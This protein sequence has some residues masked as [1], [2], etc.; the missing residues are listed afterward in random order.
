MDVVNHCKSVLLQLA[1]AS[2]FLT[3]A[4]EPLRAQE[5]GTIRGSVVAEAS[6]RPLA[7]AQVSIPGTGLGS[8]TNN[9]GEFL[10]VGVPAGTHTVRVQMLGFSSTE[11]EVTV[12]AG[13]TAAADFRLSETAI[14]LDEL[15]VTGTAGVTR[16]KEVGNAISAIGRAQIENQPVRNTQDI[17]AG[18]SPGVSVLANSGQPGA[19][20]TIRLRGTNSITQGNNPLIYVDGVRI[21]SEGGP[22]A[23]TSRQ[24]TLPLND[25][26]ARDIERVEIVKGAAATTLYGTEAS[27]GVIQIFTKNGVDGQAPV[28]NAETSFGFNNLDHIGSKDDPTGL[29]LKQCRGE[30][31][32]DSEGNPFVDPTCPENGTWLQNGPIQRYSLSVRGGGENMTYFLSGNY[33]DENGVI[34]TGYS[35]DGGFRGNFTFSPFDRLG[36]TLS[37]AYNKRVTRW[38]PDGNNGSGFLLNVGRGPFGNF[39]GGKGECEGITETCVTNAY[40]LEQQ[41]HNYTDHFVTGFTVNYEPIDNMVHRV[42]VGYDFNTANNESLW[43]FGYLRSPQGYIYGQDWTHTKLSID[44]AGSFRNNFGPNI[45][46][47]FSWGSQIFEDRDYYVEGNAY[48]FAGPGNPTRSSAARTE[49]A[50]ER[51]IREINAGVFLQEMLGF[52]DR[53]FLTA[54]LRVDGNS[55]FG[56]NFGLQ[57]YPKLSASYVIS[58]HDF[59]P[60]DLVETMK[61]RGAIGEAGKA[62]GA[63]DAVRTWNSIAGEEGQPGFT[64]AQIGNPDLGPER[65][66][67]I[68]VGFEASAL[69]GRLGLD[70]TAFQATTYDAL[71]YVAH[72]PTQGFTSNQ[73]ENVG[74]LRN[75]GLELQLDAGLVRTAALDWRG[76]LTYTGIASEVVDLGGREIYTGLGSYAKEGY[77]IG[78]YF[79]TRVTN[80]DEIADPILEEDA[81]LGPIYP[82]R[83]VGLGT[84]L[85]IGDN[86]T[87]DVLGEHQGG[88]HLT[89]YIGYQN[90]LRGIWIPCYDTQAKLRAAA[91]GDAS[92]LSDVTAQERAMCAID[93]A[94]MDSDFWT[95]ST[96]FFK[97]RS[98]SLTYNLPE[99]WVPGGNS[100]SLT[101]AGRNLFTWT[102][103]EGSDPEAQDARDAGSNIGRRDYYNLPPVRQFIASLRVSF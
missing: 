33:G 38:V 61:L 69:H 3:L 92:A 12:A 2:L 57:A 76:R 50:T 98:A 1:L 68:E 47:N 70:V 52:N 29:F 44:Y 37:S 60:A 66:R 91:A 18:R 87:L 17:I 89:N 85:G 4:A 63:F 73:L 9:A 16:K 22:A 24:N 49:I 35:K 25:I 97:L 62:P 19:G 88:A 42:S 27:G 28:W 30:N 99:R 93:R 39:K 34:E 43:P 54:G 46:S 72:P 83:I 86:L 77:P 103:Y 6:S 15:V 100:A 53:L 45:T 40:V 90:S 80:P 41:A 11:Q 8:L 5:T 32:R 67:E 48:D 95:Q 51:R 59:W 74:T 10:I 36:L 55:A 75:Q 56:Q 64:P 84:T 7:G 71:I 13:G 21:Y 82:T 102:S 81:F 94:S 31:L 58:D 23:W 14:V 96:D 79:G 101:L 26:N 78:A 65:T 20:G